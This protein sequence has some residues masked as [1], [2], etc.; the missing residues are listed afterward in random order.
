MRIGGSYNV[1][2]G[3]KSRKRDGGGISDHGSAEWGEKEKISGGSGG[4][5]VG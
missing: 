4:V 3:E 2:K 1:N 5:V